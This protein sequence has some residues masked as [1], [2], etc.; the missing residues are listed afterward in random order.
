VIA[1]VG[2]R[3]DLSSTI[4]TLERALPSVSDPELR[5]DIITY[6][7]SRIGIRLTAAVLQGDIDYARHL[8]TLYRGQPT[9]QARIASMIANLPHPIAKG[10][11]AIRH[12]IKQFSR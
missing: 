4:P 5:R 9:G 7:D 10:A 12:R 2:R 8:R 6:M 11:I 1:D 3:E